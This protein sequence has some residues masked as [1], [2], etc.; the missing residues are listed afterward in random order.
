MPNK[1][2]VTMSVLAVLANP[3]Y[4]D[5]VLGEEE[6]MM[7]VSLE[8]LINISIEV[9]TK[10]KKSLTDSPSTVSVFTA[11]EIESL[12]I[13]N[14]QDL[15]NLVPGF[16][17]KATG[18]HGMSK[19]VA[20][21][22]RRASQN[23]FEVLVLYDGQRLNNDRTGAAV[24]LNAQLS[25]S[26]IE[27]VEII[28]GPGSAIY[29]SNAFTGVVNLVT[30]T[31][32]NEVAGFVGDNDSYG[33]HGNFS[34]SGDKYNW[35]LFV[36]SWAYEGPDIDA[37]SFG[38]NIKATPDE[39]GV[40]LYFKGTFN[41][42]TFKARYMDRD[43][44]G[45]YVIE[46]IVP[47]F[48][49]SSQSQTHYNLKYQ[50]E[51]ADKFQLSVFGFYMSTDWTFQTSLF[52]AGALLNLS[53]PPS[54]DPMRGRDTFK[55]QEVGLGAEVSWMTDEHSELLFGAVYRDP[56]V[57]DSVLYNNFD[58]GQMS[59]GQFPINYY[60]TLEPTTLVMKGQNRT[61]IGLFAQY[62]TR[63]GDNLLATFG[64]RYDDHSD[65]GS[66]INPR[67]GLVYK[68]NDIHTLKASFGQAFRAPSASETGLTN[69]PIIVGNEDLQPEK[70]KTWEL[71][72]SQK[73]ERVNLSI[74][75]FDNTFEDA[76]ALIPAPDSTK[77]HWN[78]ANQ[79][80]NNGVEVDLFASLTD[81]IYLRAGYSKYF[82]MPADAFFLSDEMFTAAIN[83]QMNKWQFNLNGFFHSDTQSRSAAG[84]TIL[85]DYW[86]FNA[87][88]QYK[89]ND[90]WSIA[91]GANNLFDETYHTTDGNMNSP[92]GLTNLGRTVHLEA[93]FRF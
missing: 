39:D 62:D 85:D 80:E 55:T 83:F 29:G 41:H 18:G 60:G 65:F 68:L 30:K 36:G 22:G 48:N 42:L 86:V 82:D 13:S 73:Y 64:V 78:N 81:H 75:L 38:Q 59:N 6:T 57:D 17:S 58:L 72:W 49:H 19:T 87:K 70:V 43:T 26:N 24:Q 63:F 84:L 23:G 50:N 35:D 44:Q 10:S 4:A 33:A 53:N 47:D 31:G 56:K 79:Y 27:R 91:L 2:L 21:R 3:S 66:T 71:N 52:P 7:G 16:Q 46:N 34:G 90:S 74:T 32:K 14:L 77:V 5:D 9:A 89:V 76:V 93:K 37:W 20:A 54:A 15:L 51:L 45:A 28:R 11:A 40:D 1:T 61:I 69:N 88:L 67:V 25:L 8:A 92:N 12:G